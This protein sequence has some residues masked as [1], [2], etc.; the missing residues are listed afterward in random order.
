MSHHFDTPTARDD[1]RINLCDFYLFR[2]PPRT[3][4]MALTV[5][6]DAGPSGPDTFRDEGLY[7]FRFDL[8]G[9]AREEVTFKTRF[10]EVTHAAGNEHRHTQSF[11]LFSP[12]TAAPGAPRQ[13]AFRNK[14]KTQ[15]DLVPSPSLH[16]Q[17]SLISQ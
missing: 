10:G 5:N 13:L 4:G 12:V 17:E 8:N 9:D 14:Q 1:P 16:L 15:L 2:G 11:D 7:V 6:P 3:V